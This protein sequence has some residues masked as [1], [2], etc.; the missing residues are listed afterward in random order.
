MENGQVAAIGA[1]ATWRLRWPLQQ[2]ELDQS[3]Q[4]WR[5]IHTLNHA[6][7]PFY[8]PLRVSLDRIGDARP[9]ARR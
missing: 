8:T 2:R 9:H 5:A 4:H 7:T 1:L 6:A 3:L